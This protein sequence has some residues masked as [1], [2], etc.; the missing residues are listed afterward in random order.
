MGQKNVKG[1]NVGEEM[2]RNIFFL[3]TFTSLP[4]TFS[5]TVSEFTVSGSTFHGRKN[6]YLENYDFMFEI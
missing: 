1:Y 4:N 3:I 5:E 6:F 2:E